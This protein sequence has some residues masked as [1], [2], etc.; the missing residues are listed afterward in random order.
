M[1]HQLIQQ[2][3]ALPREHLRAQRP[4]GAAALA[5]QGRAWL[6]HP[7]HTAAGQHKRGSTSHGSPRKQHQRWQQAGVGSRLQTGG[8]GRERHQTRVNAAGSGCPG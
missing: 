5:Q 8:C 4:S 1:L 6:W 3:K 7:V 2:M